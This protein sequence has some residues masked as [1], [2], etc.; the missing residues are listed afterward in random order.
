MAK[1]VTRTVIATEITAKVVNLETDEISTATYVISRT[2]DGGE[3]LKVKRALEKVL[4]TEQPTVGVVAVTDYKR[5]ERLYGITEE[6]FMA[7]AIE[8]DPETRKPL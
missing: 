5:I 6:T 8:L 3:N 1:M 2:F 7:N 4:A